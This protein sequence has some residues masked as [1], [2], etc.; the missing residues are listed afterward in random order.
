MLLLLLRARL[1]EVG[2]DRCTNLWQKQN[3]GTRANNARKGSPGQD[4]SDMF[5]VLH[6]RVLLE[7]M[8][9]LNT[10]VVLGQK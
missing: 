7:E 5:S 2:S 10:A 4:V 1:A 9:A 6:Y 8:T 3:T